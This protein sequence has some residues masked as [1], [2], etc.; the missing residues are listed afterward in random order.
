[1]SEC[2]YDRPSCRNRKFP[3]TSAEAIESRLRQ[4][5][6][7]L[8]AVVDRGLTQTPISQGGRHDSNVP[9]PSHEVLKVF[10]PENERL[11]VTLDAN[12]RLEIDDD[13]HHN[14]H[15]HSSGFAFLAQIR[16][17]YENL[18]SPDIEP[19]NTADSQPA[20]PQIFDSCQSFGIPVALVPP[21]LPSKAVAK[22]LVESA[23]ECVCSL[24]RVVHRPTFDFMFDRVYDLGATEHGVDELRFLP[25]LYAVMAV[26]CYGSLL[27]E[28]KTEKTESK[29]TMAAG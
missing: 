21:T 14:F 5:E 1:M 18:L 24:S 3:A 13:G 28:D 26:G 2:T 7:T 27:N 22:Q 12:G 19:G 11:E 8:N 16:Q 29:R 23:L 6:S 17:K 15:G 10:S 4:I 20:L 25:L 9:A